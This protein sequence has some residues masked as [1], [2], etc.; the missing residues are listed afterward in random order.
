MISKAMQQEDTTQSR[1][2]KTMDRID[3]SGPASVEDE[4]R[5]RTG[6][7][8]ADLLHAAANGYAMIVRYVVAAGV[9]V[10]GYDSQG[11]NALMVASTQEVR[12]ILM[13]AGAA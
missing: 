4:S 9:D 1:E 6:V 5:F 10:N 7:T 13:E 11:R 2:K 12:E 3:F 8:T